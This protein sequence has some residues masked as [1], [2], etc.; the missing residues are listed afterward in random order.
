[1]HRLRPGWFLEGLWDAEYQQYRLLAY[2]QGVYRSFLAQKLYPPLSDLIASYAELAKLAESVQQMNLSETPLAL[3]TLEEIIEFALP[4]L[5]SAIEEGKSLYETIAQALQVHIVG[6]IPLYR[7]EGYMLLRR[8]AESVIR[9]YRYEIRHLYSPEGQQVAIR[10]SLVGEYPNSWLGWGLQ[11]VREEL[12]RQ[13]SDLPVPLT[14][15]VESPWVLPLEE[16]LLPIIQRALPRW[17]QE[18]SHMG[19]S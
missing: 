12:I 1:M 13:G 10:L 8:G 7:D 16:T 9:G 6:I 14:L 19:F 18:A 3:S 15:V 11:R 17:T 2:L 4:R 5:Q